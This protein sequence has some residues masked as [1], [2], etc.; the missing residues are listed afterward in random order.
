MPRHSFRTFR[1]FLFATSVLS[2][3]NGG[4]PSASCVL[5]NPPGVWIGCRRLKP[6]VAA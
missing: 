4:G 6:E 3:W 1:G 5:A 2:R